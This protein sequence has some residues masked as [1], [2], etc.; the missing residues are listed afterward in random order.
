MRNE[1]GRAGEIP[2]NMFS[3]QFIGSSSSSAVYNHVKDFLGDV[4]A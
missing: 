1:G 3:V 4:R 2:P